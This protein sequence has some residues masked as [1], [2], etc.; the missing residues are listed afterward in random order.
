MVLQN[1]DF[2]K[3]ISNVIKALHT[4]NDVDIDVDDEDEDIR[5]AF[6]NELIGK[7]ILE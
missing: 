1:G 2:K 4:I 7:Y 3:L 6:Y 5:R